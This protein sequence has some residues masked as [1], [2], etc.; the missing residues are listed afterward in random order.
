MTK[1]SQAKAYTQ[2]LVII[3]TDLNAAICTASQ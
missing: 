3:L 1:W 2:H